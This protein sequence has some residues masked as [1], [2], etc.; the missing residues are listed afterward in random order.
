MKSCDQVLSHLALPSNQGTSIVGDG[1]F[2]SQYGKMDYLNFIWIWIPKD[3]SLFSRGTF[4][5]CR[6]IWMIRPL[7]GFDGR[8]CPPVACH[9]NS[10]SN[11]F[12]NRWGTWTLHSGLSACSPNFN[13]I[14][15]YI[16]ACLLVLRTSILLNTSGAFGSS[17]R[18]WKSVRPRDDLFRLI[19]LI[20]LREAWQN[21]K[22]AAIN[23]LI[24]SLPSPYSKLL[25]SL[26]KWRSRVYWEL[27]DRL[28][29]PNKIMWK[30][31][32]LFPYM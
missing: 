3:M 30:N 27:A 1:S 25:R 32:F 14:E 8:Q 13:P 28:K 15:L 9:R 20:L 31:S 12:K 23:N 21:L 17:L 18:N 6:K 2:G 10:V 5:H 7:T 24:E 11:S 19:G 22:P 26:V 29:E 16:V 4:F